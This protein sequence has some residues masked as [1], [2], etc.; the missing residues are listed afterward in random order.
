MRGS[1]QQRVEALL[2][3][4]TDALIVARFDTAAV[5]ADFEGDG[6]KVLELDIHDSRPSVQAVFEQLFHGRLEVDDN[7]ST[8]N[9][10]Y[11]V[12]INRCCFMQIRS[13]SRSDSRRSF[14]TNP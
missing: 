6:S 4:L 11:A 1:E 12:C 10:V 3:R 14:S 7:L 8:G 13:E 2:E 9:S 5:V